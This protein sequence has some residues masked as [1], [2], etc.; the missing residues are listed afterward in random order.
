[1]I[2]RYTLKAV[3]LQ[4]KPQSAHQT[5]Q[6]DI[7]AFNLTKNIYSGNIYDKLVKSFNMYIKGEYKNG[8]GWDYLFFD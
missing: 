1:M 6:T 3:F 8:P 7:I 5:E 4:Y 2:Y